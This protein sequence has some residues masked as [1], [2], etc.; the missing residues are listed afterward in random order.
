MSSTLLLLDTHVWLWLLAG[1]HAELNKSAALAKIKEASKTHRLRLSAI[2][3]WET[4]F[5]IKAGRIHVDQDIP[6]WIAQAIKTPGMSIIPIDH[7]VAAE[8]VLLPGAMHK[9]P[10]DRFI[11]AT[12]RLHEAL[13]VTNDSKIHA[14]AKSDH[15]KA[16]GLEGSER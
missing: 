7:R 10:A 3:V 4:A 9:D 15:V 12:A 5:L 14:Y 8:S 6:T 11:V 13:L 2:S 1:D 16:I